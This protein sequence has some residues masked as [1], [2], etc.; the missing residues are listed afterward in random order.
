[1]VRN[2]GR[3]WGLGNRCHNKVKPNHGKKKVN[4]TTGG[5]NVKWARNLLD[6]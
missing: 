6:Y 4:E 3:R 2:Q 1:M 5:I